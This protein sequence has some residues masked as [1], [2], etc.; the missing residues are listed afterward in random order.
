MPGLGQPPAPG[1]R[2]PPSRFAIFVAVT[3]VL[4]A[5]IVTLRIVIDN[6]RIEGHPNA[7]PNCD[8]PPG[9]R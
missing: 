2:S 3:S 5:G 7:V 4:V 8:T 1:S 6:D 9:L